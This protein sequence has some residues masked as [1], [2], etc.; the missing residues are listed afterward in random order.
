MGA[1][2]NIWRLYR[3]RGIATGKEPLLMI[4]HIRYTCVKQVRFYWGYPS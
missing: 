3:L 2:L 1:V 4:L